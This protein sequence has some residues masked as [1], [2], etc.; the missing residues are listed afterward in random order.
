MKELVEKVPVPFSWHNFRPTLASYEMRCCIRVEGAI[1]RV[2]HKKN[3]MLSIYITCCCTI[4]SIDLKN[5][6]R[7]RIFFIMCCVNIEMK[8]NWSALC[9]SLNPRATNTFTETL[10]FVPAD[11][12]ASSSN[13]RTLVKQTKTPHT[14]YNLFARSVR[15]SLQ[16]V[17]LF[18]C[19]I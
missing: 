3:Q 13:C 4:Y 11:H 6:K 7:V 10:Y 14:H 17:S 8:I 5:L 18:C 2:R 1:P 9:A 16:C 19:H 12:P 15:P